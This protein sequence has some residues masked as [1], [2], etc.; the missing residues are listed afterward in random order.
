MG[1]WVCEFER[2]CASSE[3]VSS[4]EQK[5]AGQGRHGVEFTSVVNEADTGQGLRLATSQTVVPLST[6]QRDGVALLEGGQMVWP[7]AAAG[8]GR[9]ES[10]SGCGR[11]QAEGAVLPI[12]PVKKLRLKEVNYTNPLRGAATLGCGAALPVPQPWGSPGVLLPPP[13]GAACSG[14]ATWPCRARWL[15]L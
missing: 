15:P 13:C 12:L 11:E 6:R 1:V 14:H 5:R 3:S 7:R 8:P 10:E 2:V 9:E 4:L